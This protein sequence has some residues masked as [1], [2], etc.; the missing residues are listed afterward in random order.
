ML[1]H[2]RHVTQE[3][4]RVKGAAAVRSRDGNSSGVCVALRWVRLEVAGV[5][6]R[7]DRGVAVSS[8]SR[9][10]A[11]RAEWPTRSSPP[12]LGLMA[13][14]A[15]LRKRAA[16][17]SRAVTESW[18]ARTYSPLCRSEAF[19]TRVAVAQSPFASAH[20]IPPPA[21]IA[22]IAATPCPSPT[23]PPGPRYSHSQTPKN[24]AKARARPSPAPPCV[25]AP[26]ASR[27]PRLP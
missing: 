14:E 4:K 8:S 6:T 26:G 19:S 21:A 7:F 22:A 27:C 3:R 23:T 16:G 13:C 2:A 18:P 15:S 25:S 17:C 5:C 20:H 1:Q 9:R 11:Q 10:L 12:G 24:R